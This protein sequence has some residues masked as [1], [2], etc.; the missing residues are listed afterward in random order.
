MPPVML[1]GSIAKEAT[2]NLAIDSCHSCY[3]PKAIRRQACHQSLSPKAE[4][5]RALVA[6]EGA[7]MLVHCVTDGTEEVMP[8]DEWCPHDHGKDSTHATWNSSTTAPLDGMSTSEGQ[9]ILAADVAQHILEVGDLVFRTLDHDCT[10]VLL[11]SELY[12][13]IPNSTQLLTLVENLVRDG[14]VTISEWRYFLLM[15]AE[16]QPRDLGLLLRNTLRQLHFQST[17]HEAKRTS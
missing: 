4:L 6:M 15:M 2:A 14:R 7:E 3:E 12:K 17:L 13:T 16:H 10:G 8:S 1:E 5:H 11:L 9:N